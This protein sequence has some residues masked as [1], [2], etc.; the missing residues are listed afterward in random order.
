MT[1]LRFSNSTSAPNTKVT[2]TATVADLPVPSQS[3]PLMISEHTS[4]ETGG[5]GLSTILM[6]GLGM[7]ALILAIPGFLVGLR[8]LF[9]CSIKP[10]IG[11]HKVNKE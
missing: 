3:D 2:V 9:Q 4:S 1:L 8:T 5:L 10:P 7:L 11:E 6:L